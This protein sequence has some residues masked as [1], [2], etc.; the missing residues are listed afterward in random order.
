MTVSEKELL[1]GVREIIGADGLLVTSGKGHFIEQQFSYA[2]QVAKGLVRYRESD[3]S[4]AVNLQQAGTGTGKTIGYLVPTMLYAALT[5]KRVAVST[6]TRYL[7]RQILTKDAPLIAELVQQYTGL[8]RLT[9]TRRVGRQNYLSKTAC[10]LLLDEMQLA[11]H[12]KHES[13]LFMTRLKRWLLAQPGAALLDDFLYVDGQDDVVVLPPDITREDLCINPDSPEAELAAY[14]EAVAETQQ[15][16]V[17]ITN[18]ALALLDTYRWAT[19]LDKDRPT[20]VM[21]YDEADRLRDAAESVLSADLSLHRMELMSSDIGARFQSPKLQRAVESL[22]DTVESSR[23]YGEDVYLMPEA[24]K[25]AA[26]K[27][28]GLARPIAK[29][30]IAGVTLPAVGQSVA[31]AAEHNLQFADAVQ[32]LER[33]VKAASDDANTCL[34]S[35]SP[36]RQYPSLRIGQPEPANILRRMYSPKSWD[37]D[38]DDSNS[39]PESYFEACLFTSATLA[40]PGKSLPGAF[41]SFSDMIGAIRHCKGGSDVPVHNVTVDLFSIFEPRKFGHLSFVLPHPDAKMPTEKFYAESGVK[42]TPSVEWIAY[43]ATMIRTAAKEAAISGQRVLALTLSY[44]D[45]KHIGQALEGLPNLIVHQPEVP[46]ATVIAQYEATS[47]SVLITPNGWEGINLPGMVN[48][49][50]ITRVPY[51]SPDSFRGTML[52]VVLR[53]RGFSE[54]KIERVKYHDMAEATRRKLRQAFGRPIRRAGDRAKVW[55]ADPRFPYP[56]DFAQS[57]DE[58]LASIDPTRQRSEL[59]ACIPE[60]FERSYGEAKILLEDGTQYTPEVFA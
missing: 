42:V 1:R 11:D 37:Q 38:G 54:D 16:D 18:H 7:Q 31:A 28:L 30:I 40:T 60:R 25:S 50:V 14:H 6:Y 32:D 17:V 36:V 33:L 53:A 47:G 3:G 20:A 43:C 59:R 44:D 45:A 41:D 49:L 22:I 48:H 55:I 51:S 12:A 9:V 46:L 57:L 5:G 19:V 52:T 27:L 4:A 35:H 34:V 39:A 15:S 2:N 58:K 10:G 26:S 56:A 8:P 29:Q 21:V 13:V 24:V 23:P